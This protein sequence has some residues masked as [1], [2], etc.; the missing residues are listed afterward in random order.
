MRALGA[1]VKEIRAERNP[2]FGGV[3]P[4]P[5]DRTT[6][7]LHDQILNS[8]AHMGAILDGDADRIGARDE[9]GNFV[10][11]HR[12][13][14][15][16]LKHMVEHRHLTGKVVKA[17]S[18]TNM[19]DH[20]CK[21]FQLPLEIVPVGF[22]Y[23]CDVMLKEKG[24]LMGGEESGGIGFTSYLP[25]RDGS[26]CALLL[27]EML[28]SSPEKRLSEHVRQLMRDVGEHHYRRLDLPTPPGQSQ[29]VLNA[30]RATLPTSVGKQKVVACNQL[31]GVKL[32]LENGWLMFRGS[33]TEPLLRLYAEAGSVADVQM[34]LDE[35]AR[36]AKSLMEKSDPS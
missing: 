33:G 36:Y 23:V 21:K 18:T 12:I 7:Q 17:F 16:L 34:L 5:L 2:L 20:L 26:L 14:A 8:Q 32:M 1:N 19:I 15:L 10:D 25:E 29:A 35:G 30:I 31:D 9:Q 27:A 3:H 22:K 6:R 11:S 4:E 13:F 24:T 28:A